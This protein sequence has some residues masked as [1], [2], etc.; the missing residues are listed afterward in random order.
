MLSGTC[1]HPSIGPYRRCL[2]QNRR[3][4]SRISPFR[5]HLIFTHR[6]RRCDDRSATGLCA[7]TYVVSITDSAGCTTTE[8]VTIG[9]PAALSTTTLIDTATLGNNDGG[10]SITVAGGIP[11]YAYTWNDPANQTTASATGLSAGTYSC[12]ITDANG[13]STQVVVTIPEITGIILDQDQ[14]HL[15]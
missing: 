13:C 15:D 3:R 8:T 14:S 7:G 6:F 11:P 4:T 1:Y 12:D 9:E 2:Q 5:W 10:A